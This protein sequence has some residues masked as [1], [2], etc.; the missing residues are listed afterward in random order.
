VPAGRLR[1]LDLL[2]RCRGFSTYGPRDLIDVDVDEDGCVW[3]I[4]ANHFARRYG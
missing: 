1:G 4:V 3:I 2:F